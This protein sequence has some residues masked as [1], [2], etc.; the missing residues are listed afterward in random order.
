[1]RLIISEIRGAEA[2]EFLQALNTGHEGGMTT[3]HANSAR[4]A[5]HRLENLI[6]S[7]GLAV[8]PIAIRA[9]LAQAINL[10]VQ[11]KRD[12][13]GK[14]LI[15]SISRVSGI[16]QGVILLGDPVKIEASGIDIVK[17]A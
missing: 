8:N 2:F 15:E 13:T 17:R 7:T 1:S 5:L 16:Q 9:Q 4:D 11:L 12:S 10:I 6:L 3:I 14:R